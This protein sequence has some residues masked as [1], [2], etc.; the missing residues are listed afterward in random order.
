MTATIFLLGIFTVSIVAPFHRAQAQQ[1]TK[2]PKIG[3]LEPV[4]VP[5]QAAWSSYSGE[6]F[7][8]SA[9]LRART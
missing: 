9:M 2:I 7:V 6:S 1:Q 8:H 3:Y 4:P 5:V